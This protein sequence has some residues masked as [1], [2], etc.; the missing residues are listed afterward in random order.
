MNRSVGVWRDDWLRTS[1]TFIRRQVLAYRH[2]GVRCFGLR[3]LQESIMTA[4]FAPIPE[5]VPAQA[6][7]RIYRAGMVQNAYKRRIQQSG[8]RLMHAHFGPDGIHCLPIARRC[9]IP[10]VVTFHGYDATRLVSGTTRYS[11]SYLSKLPGLF[12]YATKIIA[13][14]APIADSLMSLGAPTDK[15]LIHHN[16]IE[17]DSANPKFNREQSGTSRVLFVG[18]LTEKKGVDVLLNAIS[19]LPRMIQGKDL[20]LDIVGEG[21]LDLSL[22]EMASTLGVSARFHGRLPL[23]EVDSLMR[24]CAVLCVPSRTAS[25]GDSEGL[26][27]V[28]LEGAAAGIPLVGSRHSGIPSFIE[29]GRTGL[30]FDEA[31]SQVLASAIS[32]VVSDPDSSRELAENAW[33]R[34]RTDFSLAKQTAKLETMYDTILN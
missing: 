8:V 26:P 24:A 15:T 33:N 7:S 4:D 27:T 19:S 10:L 34:V 16:G 11:R 29:D 17:I 6:A 12:E 22:R 32:Q 30:L 1:E 20:V 3:N 2:Y 23:R 5:F 9:T 28:L 13:V 25:D 18:R 21:P 31:D 14:S